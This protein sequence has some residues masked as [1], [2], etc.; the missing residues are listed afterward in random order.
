VGI[1][2]NM[3]IANAAARLASATAATDRTT[4]TGAG[5]AASLTRGATDILRSMSPWIRTPEELAHFVASLDGCR[6]LALDSESDSLHHHFEK[7]CLVQ[8][9]SDRGDARLVDPL[10]LNTMD[11]LANVLADPAVLKVF[12]GADYDVTTM[13]RDFAFRFENLFDTMIAARFVGATEF[14]LQ[15][16]LRAE[17]GVEL[18]KDSQKDD[19]SRRPLTPTQEAYALADVQHLLELQARLAARLQELGRLAWV[20]EECTAVAGLDAAR[21][22]NDPEAYQ[23]IKGARALPPRALAILRE[24]HRWRESRAAATDVPA[25]KILSSETLLALAQKAPHS[26]ADLASVRGVP[27]RIRADPKPLLEAIATGEAI[28]ANEL[29]SIP[30]PV[31]PRVPEVVSQRVEILKTWRRGA[32]KAFGLDV[33][34]ILPQR[35]LDRVA[36]R[37]PREPAAL[38]EIDGIRRWRIEALGQGIVDALVS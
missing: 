24:V 7:V 38:A 12:H 5:M 31:R 22:R 15:A 13:K 19:W 11:A 3:K 23:Q 4:E 8:I 36:E 29:P 28:P 17:L 2:V 32:A 20:Q 26:P 25:F 1:G 21:R 10:A 14:G 35:L 9:A 16:L 18:S 6:A 30:R 34:I 37:A 27:Q 33:S